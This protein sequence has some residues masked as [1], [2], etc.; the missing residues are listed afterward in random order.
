MKPPATPRSLFWAFAGVFLLVLAVATTLQVLVSVTLIRPLERSSELG[1]VEAALSGLAIRV[2]ALPDSAGDAAVRALLRQAE[3]DVQR[4]HGFLYVRADGRLVAE[5]PVP[6]EVATQL[7]R[8]L[9]AAADGGGDGSPHDPPGPTG[10]APPATANRRAFRDRARSLAPRF[11]EVFVDTPAEVCMARDA[12]G[13]YAAAAQDGNRGSLPGVGA[14][15]EPP[16]SPDLRLCGEDADCERLV[17]ACLR[18][19]A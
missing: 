14:V 15:Y 4:R 12:K 1:S 6:A 2:A 19:R 9:P 11:V 8:E 7:G 5:S 18:A 10:A 13:L 16:A 3:E 17:E